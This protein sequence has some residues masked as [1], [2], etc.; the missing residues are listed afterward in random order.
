MTDTILQSADYFLPVGQTAGAS[1]PALYSNRGASLVRLCAC[2]DTAWRPARGHTV[3]VSAD[4]AALLQQPGWNVYPNK[5]YRNRPYI[6]KVDR[7]GA[8]HRH[9]ALHRT[10]AHAPADMIV[11]HINGNT[12]DNRRSNLRICTQ[13]QNTQ[14]Q[15][16]RP[17]K[18][19]RFK[20]VAKGRGE[21][22]YASLRIDGKS[23]RLGRFQDEAIAALAYDA[24]A[25]QFFGE[26]AKTNADLGLLPP[27]ESNRGLESS[28]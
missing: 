19:S 22:W 27:T 23:V 28:L 12:I 5:R 18:K 11:D 21:Y 7:S 6:S 3:I 14:N 8:H 10:I 2:G 26:F 13:R 4:D 24:A 16:L 17:N 25:E 20:G 9:I 15:R 1:A